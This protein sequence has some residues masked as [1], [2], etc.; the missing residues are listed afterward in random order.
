MPDRRVHR[1]PHP[2]DERFFAPDAIPWLEAAT[3]DLCWLFDRGYA[4][5]SSL[6]LVGDRHGLHQRQRI[7]VARCASSDAALARRAGRGI[8]TAALAGQT[9]LVDGYNLLTTIEAA[10][11]GGVILAARDGCYRDMAS[12]HGSWRKVEE[13]GP[14]IDLIGA[15]LQTTGVRECLWYLDRPVSNS[16]RLRKLLVDRAAANGWPWRVELADDPDRELA[17]ATFPVATADSAILDQCAAWVN[18]A[19]E[20][21]RGRI[22]TARVIDLTCARSE[23]E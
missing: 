18:L 7:A 6:K 1:G 8:E 22:P 16:G 23:L 14:A 17:K 9:L 12:M 11:A 19:A 4:A 2:E 21:I 5:P 10:L 3:R 20:L 15:F 13:T